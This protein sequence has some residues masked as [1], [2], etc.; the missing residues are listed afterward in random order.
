MTFYELALLVHIVAAIIWIGTGFALVL[1]ASRADRARDVATMTRLFQ[2]TGVLAKTLFI[3]ASLIVV[4]AGIVMTVDAWEFDQLWILLALVL[5]AGTFVTG[6]FVLGPRSERLG[7]KIAQEGSVSADS[8]QEMRRVM[9]LARLDFAALFAIVALM[10]L[11]PTGD[12]I[13]VL[14]VIAAAV[15]AWWAFVLSK[16]RALDE[17][18]AA[19]T[20]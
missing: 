13:G 6:A 19:A 15:G 18:P 12:D 1:F 11:K 3:P 8:L 4:I 5:Y 2:E 14:A 7:A 16:L 10:V 20:A 17:A 9:M